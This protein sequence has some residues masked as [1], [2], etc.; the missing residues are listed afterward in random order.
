M[1]GAVYPPEVMP[2]DWRGNF[3]HMAKRDAVVW[4]RF[5]DRYEENFSGFAY[6]VAI[7][8]IEIEGLPMDVPDRLGWR[9]NTALKIDAVGFQDDRAWI[10]EVRPE[11]TVSALGA[12]LTYALV[13]ER[14]QV[15]A[16][17]LLPV[18]VCETIQADVEWTAAQL[19]ITV[20]KV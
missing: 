11:A 8:G 14:D 6:D 4:L 10:I 7:G 15:F 19:H 18:I 13:C 20:V 9:Y 5:M 3:P 2:R 1:I 16:V 12:A 17:P